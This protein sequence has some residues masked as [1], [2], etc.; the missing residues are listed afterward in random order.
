VTDRKKMEKYC[1][2]SQSPQRA[3]AP[4]EEEEE[5]VYK[6][7]RCRHMAWMDL[8]NFIILAAECLGVIFKQESLGCKI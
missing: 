2:T 4:A 3:V 8:H 6:S 1:S 7:L 5:E